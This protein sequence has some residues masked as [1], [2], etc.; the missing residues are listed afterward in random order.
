MRTPVRKRGSWERV[1]ESPLSRNKTTASRHRFDARFPT[2][3]LNKASLWSI[4]SSTGAGKEEMGIVGKKKRIFRHGIVD[5]RQREVGDL[6]PRTFAHRLGASEGLIL[7]LQILRRLDKHKGCVNTVSFNADG[8]I[9]VSGSDDRMIMLWDWEAGLVRLS[10]HSG[11]TDNVFQARFMPYTDDQTIVTCAADGEVRHAQLREGGQV[12]T[13]MLAQHEGRVHKMA[14][15]PGSPHIFYSCGEDGLVQHFDLRTKC[16]TRLFICRSFQDRSAYMPIV[17]LHAIAI[18]PRNPNL[19]AIAGG[20]AFSDSSELLV[21]YNDEHIYLFSKDQGLGPNPIP[22]S[23]VSAMDRD[24]PDGSNLVPSSPSTTDPNSR[25]EPK[26]YKG[27]LNRDTIKGVSFFGPNCEYV[28]SGSDCG[29]IFIWRKKEGELLRVMEGDK[30]TVNCIEPH[31]YA[32]T[33]ASSGLEND[34]KIWTPSAMEPAPPVNLEKVLMAHCFATDDSDFD[35]D[36]DGDDVDDND[37]IDCDDEDDDDGMD[38]CDD[39]DDDD[40]DATSD[41]GIDCDE[42]DGD[43]DGCCDG[44]DVSVDD[45]TFFTTSS[46]RRKD[47]GFPD[48]CSP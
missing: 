35:Y 39:D 37:D 44:C 42:D 46:S 19:F 9:L 36:D 33:I 41:D 16:A 34:I 2:A 10:F 38:D 8:N 24:S 7:R 17:Q 31:P 45:T 29:R 25:S 1:P 21:S 40:D 14:I 20:L 11:H 43:G 3:G 6:A 47:Q 22:A 28:V 12:A 18:D 15:E 26:V 48:I 23:P 27:H 4:W 13:M 5:L 32:T 30:Y